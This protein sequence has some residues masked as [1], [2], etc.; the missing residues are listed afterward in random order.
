MRANRCC[1][2]AHVI[3]VTRSRTCGHSSSCDCWPVE[4]AHRCHCHLNT[5][6]KLLKSMGKQWGIAWLWY[7]QVTTYSLTSFCRGAFFAHAQLAL[8]ARCRPLPGVTLIYIFCFWDPMPIAVAKPHR[9]LKLVERK[10]ALQSPGFFLSSNPNSARQQ[11]QS[12]VYR[13]RKTPG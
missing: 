7:R 1:K 11:P 13:D 4:C 2:A 12:A 6:V 9:R 3:W 10:V 8:S 5:V